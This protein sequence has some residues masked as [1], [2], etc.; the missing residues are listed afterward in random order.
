MILGFFHLTYFF[1][2]H[3]NWCVSPTL[4]SGITTP[5]PYLL[6][7]LRVAAPNAGRA[8]TKPVIYV[9]LFLN[10]FAT[11]IITAQTPP[12]TPVVAAKS[13]TF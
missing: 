4:K 8:I 7:A 2:E 12:F 9:G 3:E 11:A 10:V 6:Q 13:F 1:A 5:I